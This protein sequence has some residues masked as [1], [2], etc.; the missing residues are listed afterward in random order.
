[1][2]LFSSFI[3]VMARCGGSTVHSGNSSSSSS[4]TSDDTESPYYLSNGDHP[5]LFLVSHN[6]NDS[7]Y[8]TWSRAM[9]MELTA[10]NKVG[11]VNSNISCPDSGDLLFGSWIRC[12]SM[13]ISWILNSVTKEI[14]DSW[15]YLNTTAK[16][17]EDLLERFHQRNGPRIYELKKHL[18]ALVQGAMDVN[19]YFTRLKIL[20]DEHKEFQHL[21]SCTCRAMR[22][23]VELQQR[24]Y[25][26]QFL[27]GLNDS[28]SQTRSQMLMM[29]PLLGISKVFGLVVKEEHQ[30]GITPGLNPVVDPLSNLPSNSSATMVAISADNKQKS[31]PICTH[32]GVLGHTVNK[33]YKLHG[34]PPGFKSKYK[35]N[36]TT[37]RVH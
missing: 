32:Y 27:M 31:R 33:C 16:I 1:M 20:W 3:D 34:Y 14:T 5:G 7:N 29:E 30:R 24:E 37:P 35:G 2:I 11:F 9:L 25:V 12:N 18:I 13:V 21:P 36:F 19:S 26:I 4:L 10:K 17:W 28:F 15:L 8:E 22:A 6:L 23:W